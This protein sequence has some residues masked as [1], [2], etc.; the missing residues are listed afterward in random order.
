[1]NFNQISEKIAQIVPARGAFLARVKV[2]PDTEIKVSG[3]SKSFNY[4]EL[5]EIALDIVLGYEG[6]KEQACKADLV[7]K[8]QGVDVKAVDGYASAS[9]GHNTDTTETLIIANYKEFVGVYQIE[10][11]QIVWTKSGKMN[12][13]ETL[14][15]ANLNRELTALLL[16]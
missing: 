8:G 13:A 15:R 1:M 9:R 11:R 7:Y 10:N 14:A 16:A 2:A 4:G 12:R 5:C 6:K 3:T